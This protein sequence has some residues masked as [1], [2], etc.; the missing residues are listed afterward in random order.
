MGRH[1]EK[2]QT[3][4]LGNKFESIV[5]MCRFYNISVGVY[6]GR[7]KR[8]WS[9]KKALTTA[10]KP[11]AIKKRFDHLGNEFSSRR[12]LCKH[13]GI[14]EG[15]FSARIRQGWSLED[16]LTKPRAITHGYKVCDHRGNE[17]P[18]VNAMCKAYGIDRNSYI[19]YINDGL[20]TKQ[21]I[22][23]ALS[24]KINYVKEEEVIMSPCGLSFQI[25]E[26]QNKTVTILWED[27]MR[28]TVSRKDI[29]RHRR[30]DLS[31]AS[32]TKDKI[33]HNIQWAKI[34][35]INN[36]HY[37]NCTCK[38][39]NEKNLWTARQMLAHSKT[40]EK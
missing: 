18:S 36:K 9:I 10:P 12:E 4:H 2:E 14:D 24:N 30:K 3:D 1:G 13:Y 27:G 35:V 28:E 26:L 22:E 6:N 32:K 16:S 29:R 37:Y 34:V 39:C 33:F 17:Y 19:K 21:A 20:S 8:G 31:S 25:I 7:I 38:M 11:K 40:H 15:T 5:E 23:T